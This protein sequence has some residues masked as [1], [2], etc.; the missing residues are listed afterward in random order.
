VNAAELDEMGIDIYEF[1][2]FRIDLRDRT[3]LRDGQPVPLAP[4]SF[5]L[6]AVLVRNSGRLLEKEFLLSSVWSDAVV[7]ENSLAKAISEIRRAL[8]EYSKERRFIAT[9]ARHGYRFLPDVTVGGT[10]AQAGAAGKSAPAGDEAQGSRQKIPSMAVLPFASLTPDGNDTPRAVGMADAL[11]TRLSNL[12]QIVVRPTASIFKYAGDDRDPA[13]IA[14]ELR[15]DFIISGSV[16]HV[17]ERVRVTVQMLSP[18]Q[19]RC[20]WADQFEE[21]FTHIFSMEDSV[22]S[23]VATALAPKLTNAQRESLARRNT[24]NGEAYQLYLRGGISGASKR[25]RRRRTQSRTSDRP[26]ISTRNTRWPGRESLTP[27]SSSAF[28]AR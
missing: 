21:K 2:L 24:E 27:I 13:D 16:Q 17:V 26:S 19:R 25:S 6:L 22:S 12:P 4:K 14:P 9:V 28:P 10:P 15:V 18:D 20:V 1:E 11:I 8:G 23:R 7:E 3:L 5:D